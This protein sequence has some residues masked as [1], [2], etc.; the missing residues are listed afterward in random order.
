MHCH[1]T[2]VLKSLA[3]AA[4]RR[5][6]TSPRSARPEVSHTIDS[7]ANVCDA[8]QLIFAAT[9]SCLPIGAP[10]CTRSFAHSFAICTMRRPP[11]AQPAG[12][13]RRPVLSVMSA[14]LRPR[15]SPHRRCSFG[16]KT[17]LNLISTLPMPR[18]PMNWQRCAISTPGVSVSRMKAEICFFSFPFTTFGGV[19]AITTMTSAFRPF[20]HHSFSPLRIQPLPSGDGVAMVCIFAGSEPTPG[21]VSANAEIAP[22]ARRGRDF[23]FCSGG[24]KRLGGLG[25]ADGLGRGEPGDGGAA[26]RGD[27]ADGAVVVRR[28]D[29][30]AAVLLGDFHAPGAELVEAVEEGVVVLA[31]RVDGVG[32]DVLAEEAIHLI[33]EVVRFGLVGGGLLGE[34]VDEVDVELAEE[35]VAD[36]RRLFPFRLARSLGDFHRLDRAFGFLFG[37]VRTP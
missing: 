2:S 25:D 31:F 32:V 18:R 28:A 21:S 36:E 14:S 29:P 16:M 23:S 35:E 37:H 1:A 8:I 7:M 3:M 9:A 17:L 34:G 33:E 4:S 12:M 10:H 6:S 22:L 11:A 5:R 20:V 24:P 19:C 30:E 26:P 13:V 27:E 15:P